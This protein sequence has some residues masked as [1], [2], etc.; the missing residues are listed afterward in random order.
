VPAHLENERRLLEPL[1]ESERAG[2]GDLL[3]KLL[4]AFETEQPVP[5]RETRP[6]RP[7]GGITGHD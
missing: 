1:S 4:L 3:S 2:L 5:A 6:R 7:R